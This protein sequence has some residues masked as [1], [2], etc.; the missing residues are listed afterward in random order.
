M[1]LSKRFIRI[2]FFIGLLSIAFFNLYCN[3]TSQK[4]ISYPFLNHNDSVKYVGK[5][6]CRNCHPGIYQSF[7]E[8][9]MGQSFG[10]ATPQKSAANFAGHQ[11]V[12]DSINN[13][14]YFPH[15]NRDTL[16]ITEFRLEGTDTIHKRTER[17]DYIIGSGQH[18]NSHF[19]SVNGFVYQ[20]PL[21]WYAQKGKWDLPPG[22]EK[23]KNVRFSRAIEF[24]CMSCHNAMPQIE[25]GS[26]NKFT[27]IP[28][29][30]DCERCHGPGEVHVALKLKGV[31]VDTAH[32][33]DF[34]IVNPRKLSWQRQIDLCQR[35][36]LQGNA[37][38]K[39]GKSFSDFRPGMKLS[40]VYEVY[41]PK[42]EGNDEFIMASHA[43]RL[44]QSECFIQS[45]KK[46]RQVEGKNFT[47]MNLTC[48][49]CHNPHVSVKHTGT[50]VFNAACLKCH[51]A[52]DCDEKPEALTK[53]NNN[54]VSCHM[55]KSGSIDI[56]HVSVHDHKIKIPVSN[57]DIT[58]LKKFAGI[59]CVN[60]TLTTAQSKANAYLSYVERFEG[61]SVALDSA[62]FWIQQLGGFES[63]FE[64]Q[65]HEA[66]LRNE[67]EQIISLAVQVSKNKVSNPWLFY[68]IG[69]A[70]QNVNEYEKARTYY[71][72][73]LSLA[74]QNLEFKTK[75]GVVLVQQQKYKEAIQVFE[76]SLALQPKQAD[77]WVNL[78]F[79]YLN[80]TQK[81]QALKCYNRALSLDPD[82]NQAL[83]N[84]AALYHLMGNNIAA[85]KDLKHILRYSPNQAQ[86]MDLLQQIEGH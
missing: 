16:Y 53:A 35:C 29:G 30:I 11:V 71:L 70:Y 67:W 59:Y 76:Q 60:N 32:Q 36:H 50:E 40:D 5:D 46:I 23:G 49:T 47:T 57:S 18:T 75:L 66:Y 6:A 64:I 8:T 55:P 58:S 39:P 72:D 15:W 63:V 22:F 10:R 54:C 65:I 68:R 81:D 28:D 4:D 1:F 19:T 25:K 56:P 86:V 82:H 20:L 77:A 43:Q 62:R 45:N 74:P 37:V 80:V 84:R 12:Y 79:A 42:Y 3:N 85:V 41:L 73:A 44:Q 61:E 78:G 52:K 33:I 17:V 14:S 21:T 31:F 34:S 51:E 2:P 13:L 9:G 24:E 83:L 69:Q 38:L 48:I 26:V 27:K 7:M